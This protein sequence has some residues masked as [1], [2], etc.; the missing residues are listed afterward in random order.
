MKKG[1]KGTLS[2]KLTIGIVLLALMVCAITCAIGYMEYKQEIEFI[3]NDTAYQVADVA[4]GYVDVDDLKDYIQVAR[5]SGP[6]EIDY[7]AEIQSAAYQRSATQLTNLRESMGANDV[8]IIAFDFDQYTNYPGTTE[9]W[10]PLLYLFDSYRIVEENYTLGSISA[11]NP[12]FVDDV[13]EIIET[14]Q[15]SSNYF[16]SDTGYGYNTSAQ[17]PLY[18]ENGEFVAMVGVEIPMTTL[19]SALRNYLIYTISGTL[20]VLLVFIF[21]YLT[22]LRRKI[23]SPLHM[24][25]AEAEKFIENNEIS[26]LLDTVKTNDEI[27][28]LAE[29]LLQMEIDINV[30]IENITAA[31]AERERLGAELDVAKNIQASMLPSIFPAFPAQKEFDIHASMT[32]AKEVGG[33]FYDFFMVDDSHL[34]LVMADVSGKGVPAALFM[35]IAKTLLKNAAQQGLSSSEVLEKVNNQLCENNE[36]DMFVTVWIGIMEVDTGKMVCSNAG[37]EYPTICRAGGQFELFKDPHGFVLAGMED[38]PYTEYEIQLN[39]GDVLYVYT[40]GVPEATNGDNQLF[41]NERMLVALNDLKNPEPEVLL[42]KVQEHIDQF[43]GEAP[44]FDD[45]TMLALKYKGKEGV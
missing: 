42:H 36:A 7:E 40:D 39:P 41:D 38:M 2:R 15:R 4:A 37:H 22:Y 21:G 26:T 19:Q 31:T 5:N 11:S 33:D 6:G 34:A 44:Q 12:D 9:G 28:T 13:M 14:G 27:E 25:T 16:F 32:P 45:I 23:T 20:L 17:L 18:D 30:Y 3:Y 35:V 24:V 8:Y 10:T 29:S 1:K 43:V